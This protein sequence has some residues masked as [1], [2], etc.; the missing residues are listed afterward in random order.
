M[1]VLIINAGSATYKYTVFL[2]NKKVF[3]ALHQRKGKQGFDKTIFKKFPIDAIGFRIVHGGHLFREPTL[4]TG[5][6]LKKLKQLDGL[7]PLH[8]P[9]ARE[10]VELAHR[11][12]P[13]VK[14]YLIFDTAFH[15]TLPEVNW[16]Y[17]LPRKLTDQ[18]HL[19]RYGF[20]GIVCSSIVSQLQQKKK[21][22]KK[23][24]ICHLGS[25]CSVTAVKDGKS[26]DTSM[27]FTPLEGL[28]M[29]T[30]AGDVDPGLILELAEKVGTKKLKEVLS[31][32]SGLLALSGVN[33]MKVILRKVQKKN[34]EAMLALE[35]FC[36]KAAQVIAD[37]SVA[38]EGIEL[39]TFS[40]GI[41]ENAPLIRSMICDK[42]RH[43]GVQ[44]SARKNQRAKVG[45]NIH[46]LFSK[47]KICFLH[48]EEEV[49]MNHIIRQQVE[50]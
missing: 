50:N 12:L 13:R 25:G 4:V 28:I 49:E 10:L 20:H 40:G 36:Q 39:L 24:I 47:T 22:S 35:M 48:A 23:L 1:V 5:S 38:L 45:E 43:L 46:R 18:H 2:E 42:L 33:D 26:R 3:S 41:G 21:L 6:V 7:A 19:R 30:R 15:A 14:K 17:A 9:P 29:G 31:H 8:N 34:P 27:G 44:I 37:M 32:Q 16:R 11:I